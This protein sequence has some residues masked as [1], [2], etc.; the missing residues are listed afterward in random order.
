MDLIFFLVMDAGGMSGRKL[1]V[2]I[3]ATGV[4]TNGSVVVIIDVLNGKCD[5][6]FLVICYR[7]S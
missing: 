4:M 2:V 5:T 7:F 3:V 1:L 6:A